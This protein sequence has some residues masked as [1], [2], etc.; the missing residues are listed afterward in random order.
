MPERAVVS[1]VAAASTSQE[2]SAQVSHWPAAKQ[3][4]LCLLPRPEASE[5]VAMLPDAPPVMFRWRRMVHRVTKAEGPERIAAEWWHAEGAAPL[6]GEA[7]SIRDYYRVEDD[8][9]RR[10]WL[11][12][13]APYRPGVAPGWWLHGLFA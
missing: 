7:D 13:D 12:R 8:R 3:R 9:G 11:Y 2:P 5:A 4:P 6:G 1:G 10:F